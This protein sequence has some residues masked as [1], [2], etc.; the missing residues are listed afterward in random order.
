LT[1]VGITVTT[2]RSAMF[3]QVKQNLVYSGLHKES[4]DKCNALTSRRC[5]YWQCCFTTESHD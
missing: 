2:L 4:I 5:H 1:F 3:L